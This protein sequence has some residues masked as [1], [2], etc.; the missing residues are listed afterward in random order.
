[1]TVYDG[2]V[3]PWFLPTFLAATGLNNLDYVVLQPSIER[4][5]ARVA[6]RRGRGLTD[7]HATRRMHQQFAQSNFDRR[8]MLIDPPDHPERVADLILAS[9]T[10][11]SLGYPYNR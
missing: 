1:M 6:T 3:G 10:D 5:L 8:H 9:R 7:E 11:G 2:V 4:C